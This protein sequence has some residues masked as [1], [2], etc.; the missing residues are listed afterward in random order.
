MGRAV[1]R[2]ADATA[3]RH[4]GRCASAPCCCQRAARTVQ[5]PGIECGDSARASGHLDPRA[6]DLSDACGCSCRRTGAGRFPGSGRRAPGRRGT[7]N[8]ATGRSAP[9]ARRQHALAR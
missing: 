7:R 4:G 2:R 8:C 5:C 1:A 6:C 3:E 9:G